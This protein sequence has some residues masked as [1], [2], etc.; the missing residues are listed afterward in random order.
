MS[1]SLGGLNFSGGHSDLV[2]VASSQSNLPLVAAGSTSAS[3]VWHKIN[4]SHLDVGGT[5]TVMPPQGS[6]P[7]GDIS[8]IEQWILDGAL[9]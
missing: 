8:R 1:Q 9:P 5:G 6:L 4:G 2:G 7:G 3:Y